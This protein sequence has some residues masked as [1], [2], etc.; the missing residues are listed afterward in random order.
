MKRGT[1]FSIC[2]SPKMGMMKKEVQEAI[3]TE[4]GIEN[5]G[6]AG[7]WGREW[8]RQISCLNLSSVM[9]LKRD[10]NVN[11]GPGSFDENILVEGIDLCELNLGDQ[12]KIGKN[13]VLEVTQIGKENTFNLATRKLG[14]NLLSYEGVFCK[15]IESGKI[16]KGDPIEVSC[17]RQRV[18]GNLVGK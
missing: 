10:N 18:G 7:E 4:H 1:I 15:V 6:Y 9:N 16:I 8:G 2:I 11:V 13:V 3:V 12:I 5:D 17:E 14:I